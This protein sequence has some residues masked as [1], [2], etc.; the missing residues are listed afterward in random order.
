MQKIDAGGV[1]FEELNRMVRETSEKE[2]DIDNCCG[3]RFIGTAASDKR[4]IINGIPG[5]ALGAYLDGGTLIVNGNAQDATGDTMNKGEIIIHG[6]SGDATGYSMRGGLILVQG[7]AGYRAG[8]HMKSYQDKKPALVI[9]GVSG[10]FLGEYLAGGTILVLGIGAEERAPFG[11]FTGTGMHGGKIFIRSDHVPNNLPAQVQVADATDADMAEIMPYI[12]RYC[13]EF[14]VE[15]SSLLP[16]RF[17]VLTPNANNPY[18]QLYAV[19]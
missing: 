17:Y 15:K 18:K 12:D 1:G 9:G 6:S 19:M 4:I 16:H 3:Q 11:Y 7:N 5:N 2:I 13:A 14:G 10:S 8:I